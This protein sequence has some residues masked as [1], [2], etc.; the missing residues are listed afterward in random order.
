MDQ[1]R[2]GIVGASGWMAGALTIGSEYEEGT[3]DAETGTGTKSSLSRVVALCDLNRDVMAARV[4]EFGLSPDV[5]M[6]TSYD[7]MLASTNVDAVVVAVPNNL[8]VQF[9]LK[10]IEAGKHLFLEKPLATTPGDSLRLLKAASDATVSTKL[11]YILCHYDE[12][13][14]LRGLIAEG[15]FGEL[16]STHFTYR[17][18]V[19]VS[20]SPE[21]AWKLKK[22]VSGGA[23][24]MGICH[25]ISATIFQVGAEPATV[26]CRSSRARVRAFDYDTQYDIIVAFE[27]DV[28]GVVQGNIDFAEK[29]DARHTVI[30]TEGQF[31]YTP[32]APMDRRVHWSSRKLGREYGPDAQFAHQHLDSGD[33]WKHQCSR[34]VREFAKHVING[35]K[36]DLLG[37]ESP[38]VRRTEAVIWAAEES[39]QSGSTPVEVSDP[40]SSR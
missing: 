20:E 13:E 36:D 35:E 23:V 5:A 27:N 37:L 30:G 19:T 29:Y 15:A 39:A 31:D 32:Y 25:A 6:F 17:H 4:A 16:G 18:P 28:V 9:A 11:D 26:L 38:L 22:E 1:V 40:L 10:A 34:T 24:P 12:Q 3:F 8:H 7:Q 33:V 2:V 14:K 21:Q